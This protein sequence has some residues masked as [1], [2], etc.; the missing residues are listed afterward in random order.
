MLAAT[1]RGQPSDDSHADARA[2]SLIWEFARAER[3]GDPYAL[4]FEPQEYLLRSAGGGFESASFDWSPELLADLDALRRPSRDPAILPRLGERLRQ[5][6][7]PLGWAEHEQQILTACA[8]GERVVLTIRSA[9]AELY[10]LPWELLTIKSSGQHLGELPSLLLRYEWPESETVREQPSPR[11]AGGRILFAWSAAGGAVPAAEHQAALQQACSAGCHPFDSSRDVLPHTSLLRL[12]ECL[13]QAQRNSEPIAVLHLLCHGAAVGSTFGLAFDSDEAGEARAVLD[14][15]RLRQLLTPF[16]GMLRL[17]VLS[18]CDSSNSGVLGNQLGSVAQALHRAGIATVLASRYPLSVAGSSELTRVL[19]QRLLVGLDSFEAAVLRARAELAKDARHIDWASLQL[20]A[21]SSDGEDTRPLI[22]RPYR[23]LA[24][25]QP[26]D[27]RFYFGRERDIAQIAQT[28][29]S[30]ARMVSVIGASGAGKS[31][32]I[33][34]GVLPLLQVTQAEPTLRAIVVRPGAAPCLGLAQALSGSASTPRSSAS[35]VQPAVAELRAQLIR[36]R[37]TLAELAAA[38]PDT[39]LLLVVDQAEELFS[40]ANRIEAAAF[41][42]NVME[43]VTQPGGQLSLVLTL[44]AD[45]LGVF[46]EQAALAEAV[47]ASM[48]LILPLGPSELRQAILGPAALV[49]LRFE[50]GLVDALLDAL[51]EGEVPIADSEPDAPEG[52]RR[53]LAPRTTCSLPLLQFTLE[54][55]WE[56]RQGN[57][58]TWHAWRAVGGVRG[59]ITRRAEEVLA[60]SRK[61]DDPGLVQGLFGRL[62][63]L[64]DGTPDTR[65]RAGR[66]EL[67]AIAPG[68][69]G[70]I[71]DRWVDSRLLTADEA[72]V[73]IA[74]EAL[75]YEWET[76]RRWIDD[77]RESLRILGRLSRD[78]RHYFAG[79]E[80]EDDLWHGTPLRRALA[81]KSDGKLQLAQQEADFLQRSADAAERH[82]A[83]LDEQARRAHEY[84]RSVGEKPRTIAVL[85]VIGVS[86][87]T[88]FV[89]RLIVHD[90][91]HELYMA[92]SGLLGFIGAGLLISMRKSNFFT[93]FNRRTLSLCLTAPGPVFVNHYIARAFG[94]PADRS[95][96]IDLNVILMLTIVG[97]ITIDSRLAILVALNLVGLFIAVQDPQWIAPMM[98]ILPT[99]CILFMFVLFR[100]QAREP[101]SAP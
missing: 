5:F 49:G 85:G 2:H 86:A 32:L 19:Y 82:Q 97:A 60:V 95:V 42:D 90:I 65:R 13:T 73:T 26:S 75:L 17:V 22:F 44:R 99:L 20:Y 63:Q 21:R 37:S 80:R 53:P 24:A 33:L 3:A 6:L 25:F 7:L 69:M 23:G 84:D 88:H 39:P 76:L 100:V 46:L 71:V 52:D 64:G 34:S 14:A 4:R 15:G 11:P 66:Q 10:A 47:R 101:R 27:R 28:L 50:P 51:G 58:I 68:R 77:S 9:A 31:S 89:T 70:P 72:E 59:A 61:A 48:Q 62:V 83:L 8:R 93:E 1:Q 40:Q 38:R 35:P 81:L 87:V 45:F 18:A 43:A 36:S 30:G 79:G 94:F 78:A 56:Q 67:E 12:R 54:Q 92:L 16:A 57:T 74:H 91:S 55:L 98:A 41:I 96:V 29:T